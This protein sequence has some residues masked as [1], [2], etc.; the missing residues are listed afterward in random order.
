MTPFYKD[1]SD[2]DN[3]DLLFSDVNDYNNND[4]S[5]AVCYGIF[6][7]VLVSHSSLILWSDQF[8]MMT[9]IH[10]HVGESVPV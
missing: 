10:V 4:N 2:Y 3:N 5:S 8:T 1:V 6:P 7:F 9:M